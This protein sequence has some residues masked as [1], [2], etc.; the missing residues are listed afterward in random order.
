M[1]KRRHSL[2]YTA[3]ASPLTKVTTDSHLPDGLPER[4]KFVLMEQTTTHPHTHQ[5]PP[6]TLLLW[7]PQVWK[8]PHSPLPP[9]ARSFCPPPNHSEAQGSPRTEQEGRFARIPSI[10]SLTRGSGW[11][12]RGWGEWEG[13]SELGGVTRRG[14]PKG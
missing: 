1:E 4:K 13:S 10:P 3:P 5:G 8:S 11:G 9:V 12:R 14:V 7:H 6:C 2:L